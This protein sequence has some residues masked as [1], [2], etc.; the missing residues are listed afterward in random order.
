MPHTNIRS[1][2]ANDFEVADKILVGIKKYQSTFGSAVLPSPTKVDFEIKFNNWNVFEKLYPYYLLVGFILL[3]VLFVKVLSANL[4][5]KWLIN[6][7]S[8]LIFIGFLAHTIG[9]GIRWYISGHAPWSNGYE[10][11]IYIG[12]AG[13]LAGFVFRKKSPMTLAVTAVLGG[14]ILFV[15]H[16]SFLDPQIT[17]LVP[18]LKSYWL[19]IHVSAITAS[20]GFMALG[21]L[22]AFVNLITMIFKTTKNQLRLSLSIK[23]LTYVIEM[24]LTIGLVLL[25]IGNFLGGVWANESWG[26]YWGWDPKE[27]WALASIIFY[28]FVLHMRFIPGLKSIYTFNFSALVAFASIIMTFFGVNY[29]L[30]GLHS[31]AAGDP[32]PIP[33]FVYY[34]IAVIAIISLVAYWRNSKFENENKADN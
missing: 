23:E 29:Y 13:L 22:L 7:L 26:R 34:S 2:A 15:A 3:V 5:L 32:V 12:W 4:S 18:V 30:S 31:Y 10:A 9:L 24:T 14:I 19:T 6:A 33:T 20:Y 1:L 11:T 28:A 17:N 8:I 25:S 27:T 21:A 16:L